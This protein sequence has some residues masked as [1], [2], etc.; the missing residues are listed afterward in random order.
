LTGVGLAGCVLWL[1][2]I[3]YGFIVGMSGYF[4]CGITISI[5]VLLALYSFHQYGLTQDPPYIS[6]VW[7]L[8]FLNL[9]YL[10]ALPVGNVP[11]RV[12]RFFMRFAPGCCVLVICAGFA[13]AGARSSKDL[14]AKYGLDMY[15]LYQSDA[16]AYEGFYVKEKDPQGDVRWAGE[17]SVLK[18][19]TDGLYMINYMVPP[20][21]IE[22]GPQRVDFA[23]D[24]II[25]ARD[26]GRQAGWR[27][28]Y[29]YAGGNLREHDLRISARSTWMPKS[30]HP[31]SK[32]SRKLSILVRTPLTAIDLSKQGLRFG[33]WDEEPASGIPGWPEGVKPVFCWMNGVSCAIQLPPEAISIYMRNGHP[34]PKD[35]QLRA[36]V[37][38]N[39]RK[40]L[41]VV[42]RTG[43]WVECAVG[44]VGSEGRV[45]TIN[46]DRTWNAMRAVQQSPDARELGLMVAVPFMNYR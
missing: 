18:F 32:D 7:M 37:S 6:P 39:G 22:E 26:A 45:V 17:N 16:A 43:K 2:M 4:R 35:F 13:Y 24:G 15:G 21:Y 33:L 19:A 38:L 8:V 29:V 36:H 28:R 11:A 25:V 42:F 5:P 3:A 1:L 41:A 46:I 23:L 20:Q 12:Q 27:S 30:L 31:T 44:G 14:D 40:P 9:G 34:A 10:M